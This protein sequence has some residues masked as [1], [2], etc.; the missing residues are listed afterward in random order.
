MKKA[1]KRSTSNKT[2]LALYIIFVLAI[3]SLLLLYAQG[4]EGTKFHQSTLGGISRI[5]FFFMALPI[6]LVYAGIMVNDHFPK[7]NRSSLPLFIPLLLNAAFYSYIATQ[8]E[9]LKEVLILNALPLYLG[10]N[11]LFLITVS[12]LIFI[13][14]KGE[15]LKTTLQKLFV[16]GFL[17]F[18]FFLPAIYFLLL[19]F[20]LNTQIT[21]L[22]ETV[23]NIQLV[24]SILIVPFAHYPLLKKLYHRG[25]L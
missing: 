8:S 23:L 9:N 14:L 25:K 1:S 13:N 18:C 20:H 4:V 6:Y 5:A 24:I 12:Y 21:T 19:G 16:M 2:L 15:N 3:P 22:S 17:Y 11:L 7:N 10:L